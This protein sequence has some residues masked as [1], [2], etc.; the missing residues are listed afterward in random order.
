MNIGHEENLIRLYKEILRK[1][2]FMGLLDFQSYC[3]EK[4]KVFK[5][6]ENREEWAKKMLLNISKAGYFSSD[7][8]IKEYNQDIWKI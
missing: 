2:W 6:Y 7:R 8:T 5:Q 1:D 4:E 3:N